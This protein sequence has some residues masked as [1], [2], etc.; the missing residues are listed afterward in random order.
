MSDTARPQAQ[1]LRRL[2]RRL[3]D[4]YSPSGKEEDI[5]SYVQGWLKRR[6]LNPVRQPV[7]DHRYNLVVLP[8]ELEPE[9]AFIGHLDTV[10]APDLE[11]LG[12]MEEK[13]LVHGLGA[14]D[15]KGGCAA[16]IEAF[17][18]LAE[19]GG[20][21]PP[22]ALALVVGEEE[23]GD[24]AE[25]LCQEYHFP[26]A[27]IGEPTGLTPCLEHYGY[28]ELELIAAGRRRHASLAKQAANPV[29]AVLRLLMALTSHLDKARPQAIYN[30]RDIASWPHGFVVPEGCQAWLDIHLP[31]EAP[32]GEVSMELEEVLDAERG[33][34]PGI[35][36]ALRLHTVQSGYVLP[37]RGPVVEAL[38]E[39]LGRRGRDWRPQPFPSHSDAN[40][41]W[42][43]GTKPLLLGCGALELAHG[44]EEAVEFGQVLAAAEIYFELALAL[45]G[46]I[47][48]RPQV[49]G[50]GV[51][52]AESDS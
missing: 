29:Q 4:I 47:E 9:L 50:S 33:H 14:A 1:R 31:P 22:V 25:A 11:S 39:V 6:G 30:I 43:A 38:R 48:P 12:C 13:D 41:L 37:E 3:I 5:L 35:K 8:P 24:G 52:R 7:D 26:W 44:P 18:A 19:R 15:M 32:L 27:L 21:M 10:S 45:A 16:M 51:D 40:Q 36:T 28:L 34:A 23:D 42:N 20:P 2:L 46:T 17:A 49:P